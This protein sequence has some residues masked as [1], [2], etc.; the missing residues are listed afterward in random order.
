M[1]KDFIDYSI[2]PGDD[3]Y[4]YAT[5]KFTD[6]Y[7]QPADHPRWGIFDVLEDETV[8][9]QLKSIIDNLNPEIPIQ[10]KIIDYLKVWRSPERQAPGMGPL[11]PDVER[12]RACQTKDEVL[13]LLIDELN[14]ELFCS[15]RIAPDMVESQ[16]YEI[17]FSQDLELSNRKYYEDD[18]GTKNKFIE[19]TVSTLKLCG[20]SEEDAIRLVDNY[21][22]VQESYLYPKAYTME[23]LMK[24]ELNYTPMS[25]VDA[26]REFSF[27]IKKYLSY[28]KYNETD[29]II[30]EQPEYIKA[31]FERFNAMTIDEMKLCAEY[32]FV[33]DNIDCLSDE[34]SDEAWKF[35]QYM[36]GAKEREPM[37]KREIYSISHGV[38]SEAIAQIYSEKC[39][40]ESAKVKANVLIS[41][42]RLAFDNILSQQQWMSESTR[43][44]A[45]EK[46]SAIGQKV[47]YPDKWKLDY[48]QLTVDATKNMYEVSKALSEWSYEYSLEHYYNQKVDPDEWA[49]LPHTVNACFVPVWPVEII[50]PAAI[51]QKP[52]F[53]EN[54]SDAENY[55]SIG[56]I[57]GHE[58][59]H[60]FDSNGRQFDK[61]G[62]M[63][64]WWGED[65]AKKFEERMTQPMTDYFSGIEVLPFVKCNGELQ[66]TENL[67]DYGG[68][69]I[70]LEAFK[71]TEAFVS[72]PNHRRKE[73]LRKFFISYA[74]S[75]ANVQTDEITK[76]NNLNNEHSAPFLRVN[77]QVVMFDDWYEA[78]D[79]H[80]NDK[81]YIE[82]SKRLRLW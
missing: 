72:L 38:F 66:V 2:K 64:D 17:Y 69:R 4:K 45:R 80:E 60:G 8:L 75:W 10:K 68:L 36:S 23:E 9:M 33:L 3:F 81:M 26:T 24:P 79:I 34:I 56:V 14:T 73:E 47:G 5:G 12:I 70:A 78:F 18:G 50:F 7:P 82:P 32:A 65:D 19:V 15:V 31:V 61:D 25:V 44:S 41:N 76:N 57:I 29:T 30:V 21:V 55:G 16:N 63:K 39:F 71:L 42:L 46:L 6:I 54:A 53:D 40:G 35:S 13:S 74:Q 59:T 37:W 51:L 22:N 77:A 52:F 48:S 58:M 49:M 20:Y 27:D 11:L 67:A 62:N 43:Q 28:Y 1:I